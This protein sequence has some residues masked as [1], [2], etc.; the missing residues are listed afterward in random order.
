M[1]KGGGG[2]TSYIDQQKADEE[3]KAGLR[4]RINDIFGTTDN[5]PA[6]FAKEEGDLGTATRDYYTKLAERT[7]GDSLRNLKFQAANSGNTNSSIF[8]DSKARLDEDNQI[9]SS[10][11][12]DAVQNAVN[13]L[14][15]SRESGRASAIGLVNSG[16]GEEALTS[17]N[18]SIKAAFRTAS[19]K[20]KQDLFADLFRT[21][22][23]GKAMSDANAQDTAR[24]AYFN[25]RAGSYYPTN[26]SGGNVL[27]L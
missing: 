8:A 5:P 21:A 26:P 17:A 10:R 24:M 16:A 23:I 6:Q 3:R 7:Y 15:S 20:E 14:R 13:G 9:A 22:A 27:Q 25:S 18:E 1:G 2:N 11:I 4:A 12:S 19:T